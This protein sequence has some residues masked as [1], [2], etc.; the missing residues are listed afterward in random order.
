MIQ[1][2]YSHQRIAYNKQKPTIIELNLE[3][4]SKTARNSIAKPRTQPVSLSETSR[5]TVHIHQ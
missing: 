2:E 3:K 4:I 1:N 5:D